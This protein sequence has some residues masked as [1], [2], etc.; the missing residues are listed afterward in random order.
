MP[1]VSIRHRTTYRYRNPVAFGEH[2]MLLR[3]L[4]AF[5]QRLLA[6]DLDIT[7]EPSLLRH[8]HDL[9]DAHLAVARFQAR[10]AELTI[11]SRSLVDHRPH[12]PSDADAAQA[13]LDDAPFS[14]DADEAATLAVSIERRCPDAG[15]V[16]RWTRRFLRPVGRT[17]VATL[18]SEMT[19]HIRGSFAYEVRPVGPPQRPEL[20]LERQRG[21]CRDFAL[22]IVEAARSVGLAARFVSGY[23][24]SG[25]A[26][27][28]GASHGHTH[29]WARIYLPDCGWTD[30]DPT[31]GVIGSAGLIRVAVAVDPR[32]ALPLHG[33]WRGLASDFIGMD[34]VV[35]ISTENEAVE[36][37][38]Q[39]LRV[40]RSS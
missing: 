22:L 37:P 6:F 23:V 38:P 15:E 32:T 21:S 18:L 25:S 4:E 29:A 14:Y 35:D 5:D 19:H 10:S 3:P 31:N 20:T 40:A 33:S 1:I 13:T 26:K 39:F 27:S 8:V 11:E 9:T 12:A 16:E 7:P 28:G 24:Y 34:V 30:F 36:Q 17:R 2:R